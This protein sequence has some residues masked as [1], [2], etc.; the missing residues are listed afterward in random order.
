M[1]LKRHLSKLIAFILVIFMLIP[2]IN[3]YNVFAASPFKDM[4]GHWAERYVN[5]L[6][7]A[8]VVLGDQNGNFRPD[9]FITVGDA[10]TMLDKYYFNG[11]GRDTKPNYWEGHLDML[12]QMGVLSPSDYGS[13]NSNLTRLIAVLLVINSIDNPDM[14]GMY[15][16]PPFKDSYLIGEPYYKQVN[17]AYEN[18]VLDGYEDKSFKPN[19]SITRAEFAKI[20]F[21]VKDDYKLK[22]SDWEPVEPKVEAKLKMDLPRCVTWN[23][24]Q[25]DDGDSVELD[26]DLD[27]SDSTSNLPVENYNFKILVN[28]NKVDDVNK[29][30]DMYS[31]YV[32]VSPDDIKG[33]RVKITA[34]V[35]VEDETGLTDMEIIDD[36]VDTEV[37]NEP[38]EAYFTNSMRNYVTLPV[39][40]TNESSDPEDDLAYVS[41]TIKNSRGEL[42]FYSDTDLNKNETEQDYTEEY[43]T[44]VNFNED[45]GRLVFTE[46]GYYDVEIHVIDNGGGYGEEEDRYSKKIYVNFEP[47][48]PVADFKMYEFG[49]PNESVPITDSSTDPN[50]DI[51]EWTWTKPTINKDDK[52][53]ASVWGSLSG[54]GGSL[55]FGKEGTYEVSLKVKDYTNLEDSITKEIKIIPPVP[56]ARITAEG[57]VKEN[58][59]VTLHMRDS[60]SPRTDRIQTSRNIWK[61]TP[62]DG[63][64]PASIKIDPD[65]SNLEEK[66]IVFK[67]TGR[68]E[69]YLKVH[70]NFSDA[71]PTHPN[72]SAS[73]ITEIITVTEDLKPI[74]EFTVGGATPNFKDN[75]VKTTVDIRQNA[76]SPDDDIIAKYRY[77]IYRDMDED[78]D[79]N[80]EAVYGVYDVGDTAI[81]VYFQQGVSGAFKADLEVVEEFGQPTIEK[82]VSQ[83]D[84]RKGIS[85]RIFH[86][87]WIPDI[88]FE[89][90]EWA[91]TDDTLNI[92]TVLKDEKIN[93]L[94]V[95]W[96]IKRA[97]ETDTSVMNED[98]ITSRTE[99]TLKNNGGTIRF[100]DSGYYELTATVTDEIGQSYSYSKNIR[101]YPLPT[102]VIKDGMPYITQFNS[103]ENRKYQLNGNSSYANDYY[104]SELHAI[105]RSRDYW[106]IVPLDGQDARNNIKVANG[107]GTLN[108]DGNLSTKY[109]K[110]NNR[111]E[112]D[113]L[114]KKSGTYMVRYQVTN[115]YGKKSPIAEQIITV[116][117]DTAP[118]ISMD[119]VEKVYRDVDDGKKAELIVYNLKSKSD[120]HDILENSLHRVRYRFDSDN[121]GSFTDETWQGPITIDFVNKRAMIKNMHVGRY[122]FEFY[123][124]DTFGQ[125]TISQFVTD[126]DRKISI[127]TKEIEIDNMPPIVDFNVTPSNKVDVVFTVGQVDKSKILELDAKINNYI[128]V[129]LEANNADFIDT[130][131]ETISTSGQNMKDSFT[132]HQDVSRS[133]GSISF[134]NNGSKIQMYGNRSNSG[135]NKIYTDNNVNPDIYK[136][137]LSFSYDLDFGD[138]FNGAG[139]LLNTNVQNNKLYGYA[140]M[141]KSSNTLLY[142][143]KGIPTGSSYDPYIQL[144]DASYATL[145]DTIDMGRRGNFTI[146]T[147]K[148][149]VTVIKDGEILRTMSLPKHYGWGLGFFSDHYS[150]NCSDIGQ[151]ALENIK[152][153]TTMGKSLDEVLKQPTWRDDATRFVINIS[154]VML[155]EL[156]TDSDK[157]SVVLSR[158]LNDKL[159]FAELGTGTNKQQAENFIKD[160][161]NRGTFIYNNNPNMDKALQNLA[162]WILNTVR[163]QAR[164]T[165]RYILLN[166]EIN[167]KTF[168]NDY[169]EDPKINTENWK[170]EHN[171]GYFTNDLGIAPYNNLWLSE[172]KTSF[173][174]VGLFSTEYRTKDNPVGTDNRFDEYRKTSSMKNGPLKIYVH[175]KPIAQFSMNMKK[176]DA[177]RFNLTLTDTSYDLDHTNRTDKGLVAREW[178]WKKVGD[179]NWT[180]G[181]LTGGYNTEEYL[182]RLRVRDMDG[183]NNLG[184]WSDDTV[185]L[186]TSK[187]MPPIAQFVLSHNIIAQGATLGI[188]DMSYDPNGDAIDQWEW[189]LYK[190]GTLL[191]TYT[192][193]DSQAQINSKL[194]ASGIGTFSITLQVKDASG[195]WGNPLSTSE[196]YTQSFRVAPVNHAPSANFDLASGESPLWTFPRVAGNKTYK[197]RPSS[198]FFHEELTKFNV[199]VSDT[200]TDNLGFT[201]EWTLENYKVPNLS[202]INGSPSSVV[203]YTSKQ[204]FTNSF[205]NQGLAWGAYK[206]TLKVTDNPPIP[207]Y[208]MN[209]QLSTYVTKNYYII[210]DISITGDF[211]SENSEILVGDTIKVKATTNREVTGV[212]A[213]LDSATVNLTKK[214]TAGETVY[215][216]GK[217]TIPD[218]IIDSGKY[219]ISFKAQTNYGGNGNITKEATS[220]VPINI[221][222][223]KLIN[224]RI[225]NIVNHPYITF[226]YTKDM[227]IS[228]LI[229]YKTGYY[230]TFQID[231]KGSP[232]NIYANVYLENILSETVNLKKVSSGGGV[233]TWQGRFYTNA[234]EHEDKIIKIFLW[235]KKGSLVYDYNDKESWNG[236]SLIIK[237]SAFQDGRV[238]L[239]N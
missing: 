135:H 52:T 139:V 119:G 94:K 170:Y 123:V 1:K 109:Y 72:I 32:E 180:S 40:L 78:G 120:D 68:Y 168:Y 133:M 166:E 54:S 230:V 165:T 126:G 99:N 200:N 138:S 97:D 190:E 8:G 34:S 192:S 204:P 2:V 49:Y 14:T 226:P 117:E 25:Y 116:H 145:I 76:Y 184:V 122:Q 164:P 234:R 207:P 50:N 33:G 223:L 22:D 210:P 179:A 105:D 35:T 217:L 24:K 141:I 86:V 43:F 227:L 228:K 156:Q 108:S 213:T 205:K 167:Y 199:S 60:L 128:K 206:I 196:I 96:T 132:W 155:S 185:V 236:R 220:L 224:F 73:E 175:R 53:P 124:K 113:L 147:T 15:Y 41:W 222:A 42:I 178:S 92:N 232:D 27:A 195:A 151:F 30:S 146:Q 212:I 44:G 69:V 186:I 231:S 127:V 118:I 74:S 9:E 98:D 13:V 143:L 10:A 59:K 84:R 56:V 114:F 115:A 62:L 121:D 6:Y 161:D 209:S 77:V 46:E 233:E 81:E 172:P 182:V 219:N 111:F 158:M 106:E 131:I 171:Y 187:A 198:G 16:P 75:P 67:E 197:Y 150:H 142:E 70:N 221:I 214:S 65:T 4:N 80:D 85:S 215:W 83:A 20:L 57:A 47:Q 189:K 87:N 58:R 136:Q 28:G 112:E 55:T 229:P 11:F 45:G 235:G 125:D 137:E 101:I 191:G 66:N 29:K 130:R 71:N 218:T 19:R 201:Y 239:T 91:Y 211:E 203:H 90:P 100:K 238:N 64:N 208:E 3:N 36:Y 26:V 144:W 149:N 181:K 163:N 107:S 154:D 63:Q 88:T 5:D 48:P 103:K 129:F 173:D 159:H 202:G 194:H 188:T 169:E 7:Y 89:L 93:T 38:P 82:F 162:V 31:T 23:Y 216:E 79:F 193:A 174:K 18:G 148:K 176:V 152:L 134:Q 39:T 140:L 160:N 37:I 61:I 102:A 237:G 157:Y 17:F 12:D 183:E 104:G 177:A 95:A 110:I 153:E 225:T 21:T 51:V